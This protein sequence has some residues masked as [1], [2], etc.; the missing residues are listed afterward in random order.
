MSQAISNKSQAARR[1]QQQHLYSLLKPLW[2]LKEQR[3]TRSDLNIN[4][5]VTRYLCTAHSSLIC[6]KCLPYSHIN[7]T[8]HVCCPTISS[9]FCCYK[10]K[11]VTAER[12]KVRFIEKFY[13][14][15]EIKMC[16]VDM[17]TMFINISKLHQYFINYS[18]PPVVTH[19]NSTR[20]SFPLLFFIYFHKESFC[21]INLTLWLSFCCLVYIS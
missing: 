15:K 21:S 3:Q 8:P 7:A 18:V 11:K 9:W 12:K 5:F 17:L 6:F 10:A 13:L 4:P 16:F 20:S 2:G 14:P 1:R 19:E